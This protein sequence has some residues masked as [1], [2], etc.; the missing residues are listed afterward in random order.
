MKRLAILMVALALCVSC[1]HNRGFEN[2]LLKS[3]TECLRISGKDVFVYDPLT[4]QLGYNAALREYRVGTDTM[5]DYFC[6]RLSATPREEGQ[7]IDKCLVEWTTAD[8]MRSLKNLTF[9]VKR[10]DES[11]RIWLWCKSSKVFVLVR[12]L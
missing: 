10:L 11:G 9:E 5:S 1:E 8:D 12:S 7:T 2:A 3:E 6:L 4:C